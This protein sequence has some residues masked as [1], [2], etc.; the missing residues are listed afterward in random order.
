MA[1]TKPATNP[2]KSPVQA[3]SRATVDAIMQAST[4]ILNESGWDGLNT[5]AIAERAGVNVASI[6]QF[7][8][9]KQAIIAELERKHA[10]SI[11]VGILNAIHN[12]KEHSTLREVL[13]EMVQMIVNA[14]RDTPEV[15]KVI[16]EELPPSLRR[17]SD[18]N[19]ELFKQLLQALHPLMKNVPNQ[20]LALDM[21]GIALQTIIHHVT[22]QQADLLN[23]SI[24]VDELVTL[25]ERFLIRE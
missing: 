8:P 15:H 5:N 14:H 1:K 3:R 19:S 22:S 10:S 24:L 20:A 25:A 9:N 13:T 23:D 4:Y 12:I 6:Y 7:F 18:D 17:P 21:V 2:R 11:H 16:S